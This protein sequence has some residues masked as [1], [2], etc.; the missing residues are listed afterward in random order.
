MGDGMPQQGGD[1]GE[2]PMQDMDG[3]MPPQGDDMGGGMPPQGGGMD[4]ENP[5]EDLGGEMQ[6]DG[7]GEEDIE[8]EEM[9]PDDEVI[10]VDELTQSQEE[11]ETKI[12]GVDDRLSELMDMISKYSKALEDNAKNIASLKAEFEKRNP[13][14]EER[15]NIRSQSSYPY[16]QL[17][18]DYWAEFDGKR[19][20]YNVISDNGVQPSDEEGKYELRKKDLEGLDMK[21]VADTLNIDQKLS[22]YLNF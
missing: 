21:S 13:T 3:G 17:P 10:D 1:M 5:P 15:L 11:T 6:T 18:K 19:P 12:E 9:E 8:T 4:M 22:D 14:D 20:N 16:T 2:P 7:M